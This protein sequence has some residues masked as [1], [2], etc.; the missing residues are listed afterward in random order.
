MHHDLARKALSDILDQGVFGARALALSHAVL[1]ECRGIAPPALS[2][3]VLE[4]ARALPAD[5]MPAGEPVHSPSGPVPETQ[6]GAAEQLGHL[7]AEH[8][9]RCGLRLAHL[10]A[11]VALWPHASRGERLALRRA[12]CR[13]LAGCTA[14]AASS[15]ELARLRQWLRRQPT[16]YDEESPSPQ[17]LGEVLDNEDPEQA[18]H[19]LASHL[20]PS[21]DLATLSWTLGVL[22]QRVL[23][24][25]YDPCGLIQHA[26]LGTT[27]VERLGRWMGPEAMM[28][29][30]HQLAHAIWW[31]R[32]RPPGRDLEP[33]SSDRSL[34]LA[35]AVHRGDYCAAQRAARTLA[36]DVDLFMPAVHRLLEEL[37]TGGS[38]DWPRALDAVL[39][40]SWR[41]GRNPLSPDDAAALGAA[42]AAAA[43]AGSSA[44]RSA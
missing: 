11:A 16:V 10:H 4:A 3:L 2:H 41:A 6:Q 33:G 43:W 5:Q 17:A 26:L 27:V 37:V 12:W 24:R 30:L 19:E 9:E 1:L 20:G 35:E 22:A 32:H 38:P 13:G 42:L 31:C 8:P 34:P 36:G 15:L 14:P 23:L 25:R 21:T 18:C 28:V 40:A 29:L 7:V 44:A 39:V